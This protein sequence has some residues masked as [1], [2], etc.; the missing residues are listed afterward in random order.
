ML[1]SPNRHWR[2]ASQGWVGAEDTDNGRLRAR[3][4]DLGSGRQPGRTVRGSTG[5]LWRLYLKLA[6]IRPQESSFTAVLARLQSPRSQGTSSPSTK[7]SA[8]K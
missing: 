2:R 3:L 5:L 1:W 4:S 7:L 6:L 8:K